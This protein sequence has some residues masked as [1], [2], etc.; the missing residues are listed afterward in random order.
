MKVLYFFKSKMRNKKALCYCF[1]VVDSI[2]SELTKMK[3]EKE[4]KM[5]VGSG[6]V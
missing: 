3:R 5:S 6:G 2:I 4:K 1:K